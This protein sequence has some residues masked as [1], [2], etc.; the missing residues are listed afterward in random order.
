M[1][2]SNALI[3]RYEVPIGVPTKRIQYYDTSCTVR[4]S[5]AIVSVIELVFRLLLLQVGFVH[6]YRQ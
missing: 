6:C 4:L 1:Y 3:P 2:T 5:A